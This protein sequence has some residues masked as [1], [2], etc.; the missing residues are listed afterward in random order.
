MQYDNDM[1]MQPK[2]FQYEEEEEEK[3]NNNSM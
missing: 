3:N 1:P 2:N